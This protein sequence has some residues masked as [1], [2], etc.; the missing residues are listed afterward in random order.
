MTARKLVTKKRCIVCGHPDR[1]L[2]EAARVAGCSLDTIAA[3]H[4]I[5]RD[6]IHRT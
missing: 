2:I 1:V 5:S 6:S 4:S 3:K